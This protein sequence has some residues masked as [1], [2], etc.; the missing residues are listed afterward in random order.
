MPLPENTGVTSI[1]A[2]IGK[3][4]VLVAVNE[5]ILPVPLAA[6]PMEVLLFVQLYEVAVPEKVIAAV[7]EPLQRI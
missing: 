3:V 4:P 1:V 7:V 6:S 2:V 5:A